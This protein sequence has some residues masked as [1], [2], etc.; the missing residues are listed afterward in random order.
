M[1]DGNANGK[2]GVTFGM[3]LLV[4]EDDLRVLGKVKEFN[5]NYNVGNQVAT[6]CCPNCGV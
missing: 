5:R 3:S 6:C 2:S 1:I 4:K